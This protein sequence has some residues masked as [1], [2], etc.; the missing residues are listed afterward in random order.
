MSIEAITDYIAVRLAANVSGVV[1]AYA[2]AASNEGAEMY[3]QSI[4]EGPVVF[5][6]PDSG[7]ADSGNWEQELHQIEIQVWMPAAETGEAFKTL[8]PFAARIK[9][10]FRT[11][12]DNNATAVRVSYVGYDAPV[13]NDDYGRPFLVLVVQLEALEID[14]SNVYAS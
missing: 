14:L 10:E 6:M 4:E 3:P 13:F 5:V 12:T 9:V 8:V 1:A 7:Q 11:D 2:P